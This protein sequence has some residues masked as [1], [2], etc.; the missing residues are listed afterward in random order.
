MCKVIYFHTEESFMKQELEIRDLELFEKKV[1]QNKAYTIAR[2]AVTQNGIYA[3]AID[4]NV[5]KSL[6]NTFSVDVN[7][8][9]IT[10]QRQSGRCWMFAGLDVLRTILMK[11]LNVKTIELSQAYLQ[12]YDKLEKANFFLEKAIALR[13][14]EPN[15]RLNVYLLDSG[16]GDGGHFA[17]FASLVKKYGVVPSEEMPDWAVSKSTGELNAVLTSLLSKDMKL[18][19]EEAKKGAEEDKIRAKKAKMLDEVYRVL[20]I[21]IGVPPKTFTYTYKEKG[22][23]EAKP[24]VKT[25]APLTPKEFYDQYIAQDFN[26]YVPLCDAPIEGMSRYQ[27]YTSSYVNN[28]VGGDPVIFFNVKMSELKKACIRSLKGGDVLWFGADVSS[29]S[30]RKEGFLANDLIRVD[31]LMDITLPS[32]KGDRLTYRSSFCNHAMTLTG[33][34]LISGRPNRWKVENSW[35]KEVGYDGFFV[36]DD[37]WFDN[38]VYEVFVNRK[39]VDPEVLKKYDASVAIDELPFNTLYLQMK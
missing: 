22:E 14:E 25:L 28:V 38:Y 7:A 2:R 36:M 21:A 23:K 17:M 15:S 33:V 20:T 8:G 34:N 30:M 29:E 5:K 3:S 9:D 10:N 24:Q 6:Q 27:K 32:D 13:N 39:Y 26:E 16:I 31:E 37:S 4:E 35:G 19:H 18:I 1:S 11:K 12:F